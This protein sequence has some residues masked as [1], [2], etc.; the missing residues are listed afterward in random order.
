[1]NEPPTVAGA[2][3]RLL[4]SEEDRARVAAVPFNDAGHGYDPF[5]LHPDYVGL[6]L[7][8]V[9]PLHRHWFRVRAHGAENLPGRGP[10]IVAANHSGTLPFDGAMLW[11]DLLERTGRVARPVADYFVPSLPFIGT[12]FARGGMVGGTR[13]NV[14]AL[15]D[16]GELLMIFPEGVPGIGK[17]FRDRYK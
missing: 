3:A 8:L 16:A 2:I 4:L 15:L 14:R 10:A 6:G 11:V 13:G 7:G 17:H 12:L 1:M 5:G 9:R